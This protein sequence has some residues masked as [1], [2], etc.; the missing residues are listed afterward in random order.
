[1]LN[2]LGRIRKPRHSE[3]AFAIKKP[4][5]VDGKVGE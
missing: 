4:L 1:L 2:F 5:V 3:K